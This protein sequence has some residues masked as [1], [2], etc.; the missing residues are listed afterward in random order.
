MAAVTLVKMPSFAAFGDFRWCGGRAGVRDMRSRQATISRIVANPSWFGPWVRARCWEC[1]DCPSRERG[2][3]K[4][5][6]ARGW[7]HAERCRRGR[8]WPHTRQRVISAQQPACRRRPI[9]G[10]IGGK[11]GPA[12]RAEAFSAVPQGQWPV[13]RWVVRGWVGGERWLAD[14]AQEYFA[15]GAQPMAASA[16]AGETRATIT[17]RSIAGPDHGFRRSWGK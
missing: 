14:N 13:P 4:L 16:V 3:E 9:E 12:P 5:R 8:I 1:V 10:P 17:Q 2:T 6:A 15:F 7:S 11:S